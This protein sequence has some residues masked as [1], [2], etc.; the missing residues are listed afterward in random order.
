MS[1]NETL[2]QFLLRNMWTLLAGAVVLGSGYATV[3][4]RI[5]AVSDQQAAD[6]Q[7]ILRRLDEIQ[8]TLN[9]QDK[10]N[11]CEIRTIDRLV[12]RTGVVPPCQLQ[13]E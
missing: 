9:S 6:R 11:S 10:V 5:N 8:R 13:G 7:A 12:E 2:S 3:H 4:F 1:E